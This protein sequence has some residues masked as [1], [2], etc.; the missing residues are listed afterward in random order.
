MRTLAQMLPEAS[1]VDLSGLN[2]E[3]YIFQD[4]MHL[5]NFGKLRVFEEVMKSPCA[6]NVFGEGAK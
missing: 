1:R 2:E 6:Q 3:K 5:T 4:P